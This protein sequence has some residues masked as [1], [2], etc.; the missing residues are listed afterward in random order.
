MQKTLFSFFKKTPKSQPSDGGAEK[1]KTSSSGGE[2][3][4]GHS[5]FPAGSLVWS[6]LPGYPWNCSGH[7]AIRSRRLISRVSE[8]MLA[9]SR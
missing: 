9:L 2:K 7:E 4:E 3:T 1:K 8:A 5:G 6:K